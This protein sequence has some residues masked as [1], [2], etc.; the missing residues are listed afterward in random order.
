MEFAARQHIE[1]TTTINWEED[2][3]MRTLINH[4]IVRFCK[5]S[6]V[7][8]ILKHTINLDMEKRDGEGNTILMYAIA[9]NNSEMVEMLLDNYGADISARTE[10]GNSMLHLA[11][12]MNYWHCYPAV[13]VKLLLQ[14]GADVNE[15]D[16]EGFTPLHLAIRLLSSCLAET[17]YEVG[18]LKNKNK[19]K[20]ESS[21]A[22]T[23]I[24]G[25]CLIFF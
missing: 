21:K 24:F 23:A 6:T 16:R 22:K 2:A 17:R 3:E 10:N 15:P 9:S 4:A 11:I 5:V 14:H 1:Y 25:Y 7:E 8:D 18:R 13:V 20:I 12:C 19:S